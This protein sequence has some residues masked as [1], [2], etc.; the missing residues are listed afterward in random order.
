MLPQIG[1]LTRVAPLLLPSQEASLRAQYLSEPLLTGRA[2]VLAFLKQTLCPTEVGAPKA[3]TS[4]VYLRLWILAESPV[5]QQKKTKAHKAL[6][7]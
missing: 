4:P 6:V 2:T 5:H 1:R 3:S 7:T